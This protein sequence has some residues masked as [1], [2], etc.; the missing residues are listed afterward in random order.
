MRILSLIL[1]TIAFFSTALYAVVDFPDLSTA[2]GILY[3]SM[4]IT[5][6]LIC[7]T[8]IILNIPLGKRRNRVALTRKQQKRN[9][10]SLI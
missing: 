10:Y 5:L 9:E 2:N 7:I 8:G 4:L 6:L 1:S 3:F